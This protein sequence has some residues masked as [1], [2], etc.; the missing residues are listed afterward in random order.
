MNQRLFLIR[1][2]LIMCEQVRDQRKLECHSRSNSVERGRAIATELNS[3]VYLPF[4]LHAHAN[5]RQ[6]HERTDQS[7]TLD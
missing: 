3:L 7:R 2:Q 6:H 1:R 5:T 4:S